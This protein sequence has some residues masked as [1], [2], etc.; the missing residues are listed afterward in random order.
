MDWPV[1]NNKRKR[2]NIMSEEKK[3]SVAAEG[4]LQR[5]VSFGRAVG[6]MGGIMIGSGIF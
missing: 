2:E 1:Q 3:T 4:G 5:N 6:T